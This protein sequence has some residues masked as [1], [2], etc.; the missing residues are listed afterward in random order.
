MKDL[1]MKIYNEII[2]YEETSIEAGKL[3][4]EEAKQLL[5][6]YKE[7]FSDEDLETVKALMYNLAYEAERTGFE[8]GVKTAVQILMEVLAK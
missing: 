8:L 6:P 7:N 5:I 3:L 1:L 4:D 2:Q